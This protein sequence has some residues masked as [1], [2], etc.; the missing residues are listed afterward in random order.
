MPRP[1]ASGPLLDAAERLFA[2]HGIAQVSDRKI[3]E[4]AGNNNHSAVRYYFGGR[5]GL[6]EALLDRHLDE[7]EDERALM[8]ARSTSLLD[9]IRSLVIP[10]TATFAAL[11]GPSWRARFI[12]QVFND[13]S[14]VELLRL[15][16]DRAPV[17]AQILQSVADRLKHLDRTIVEGRARLMTHL[18]ITA[19][20]EIEKD[21]DGDGAQDW[22]AAGDFL[23][24]AIA[25]MLEA[26]ISASRTT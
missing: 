10:V 13:P 2:E 11:P 18:L 22:V 8:F 24:D 7:L 4:E 21:A 3:A 19:C 14:V 5:P 25:G 9:D 15:R 23:C 26:P 1:D 17:V 16:D 6:L 20:A 12:Q